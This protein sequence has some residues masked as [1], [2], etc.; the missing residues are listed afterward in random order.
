MTPAVKTAETK[1]RTHP[2]K[3]L[4]MTLPTHMMWNNTGVGGWDPSVP[5]L[6]APAS[7]LAERERERECCLA[8][9]EACPLR[10]CWPFLSVSPTLSLPTRQL[11]F[12]V[13]LSHTNVIPQHKHSY[14]VLCAVSS[15]QFVARECSPYPSP[16]LVAPS[17]ERLRLG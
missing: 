13:W 17:R 14:A 1:H 9:L 8:C 15:V 3:V 2:G 12:C 10:F 4:S 11:L 5:P 6:L 16:P 7:W